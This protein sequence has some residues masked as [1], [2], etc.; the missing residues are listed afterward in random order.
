MTSN[1]TSVKKNGFEHERE[2]LI[3]GALSFIYERRK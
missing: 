3:T 2:Y 1:K